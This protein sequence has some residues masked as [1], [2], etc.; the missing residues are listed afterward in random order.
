[1]LT[2]VV[3]SQ[4]E[5]PTRSAFHTAILASPAAAQQRYRLHSTA[6]DTISTPHQEAAMRVR[7]AL[8]KRRPAGVLCVEKLELAVGPIA[9]GLEH[10]YLLKLHDAL[11]NALLPLLPPPASG[12]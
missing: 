11:T 12:R 4:V 9:L 10:L 5:N 2:H 7:A 6:S 8:W 3:A 1:M